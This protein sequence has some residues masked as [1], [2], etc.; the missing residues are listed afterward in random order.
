MW[1]LR[2]VLSARRDCCRQSVSAPGRRLKRRSLAPQNP[3]FERYATN[4]MKQ[5]MVRFD[6]SGVNACTRNDRLFDNVS[7]FR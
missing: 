6:R 2:M 3:P 4:G 5:L 7:R 1:P